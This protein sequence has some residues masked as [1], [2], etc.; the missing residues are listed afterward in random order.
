MTPQL[1]KFKSH[2]SSF[3]W[4]RVTD[5]TIALGENGYKVPPTRVIMC[6]LE[7]KAYKVDQAIARCKEIHGTAFDGR[8]VSG[9]FW[10]FWRK[11]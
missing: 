1:N 3:G 10:T 11:G 2:R 8:Y 5:S 6:R 9:R 4:P 7:Y